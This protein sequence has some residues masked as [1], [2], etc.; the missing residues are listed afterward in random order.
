M[1]Y[2]SYL[3]QLHDFHLFQLPVPEQGVLVFPI[4]VIEIYIPLLPF[5]NIAQVILRLKTLLGSPK[6]AGNRCVLPLH[7]FLV[8]SSA[9]TSCISFYLELPVVDHAE[10]S[11]LVP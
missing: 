7:A 4:M 8:I 11:F 6:S 5:L 1:F 9:S 10:E 3:Q 2:Y